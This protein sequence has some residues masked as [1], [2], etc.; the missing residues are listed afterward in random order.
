M[1][2]IPD[3]DEIY[4]TDL[5]TLFLQVVMKW[6]ALEEIPD[7]D[8]IYGT[9]LDTLFLQVVMKWKAL[10]GKSGFDQFD[11][12][13]YLVTSQSVIKIQSS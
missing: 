13:V 6:K 8:E 11:N 9:D 2:E 12:G 5:D 4:G 3:P 10:E 1:S 7:P